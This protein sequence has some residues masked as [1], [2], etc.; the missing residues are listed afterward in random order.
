MHLYKHLA[1]GV[2]LEQRCPF[3]TVVSWKVC[4]CPQER[5]SK[6]NGPSIRNLRGRSTTVYLGIE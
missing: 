1:E 4:F 3:D 6:Q 2:T 5:I